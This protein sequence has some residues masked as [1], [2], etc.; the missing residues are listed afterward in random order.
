MLF[1]DIRERRRYRRYRLQ[2]RG[3]VMVTPHLVFSYAVEDISRGGLA[4][5]YS[6]WC[7]WRCDQDLPRLIFVDQAC[8]LDKI[9]MRVVCDR[10]F[11]ELLDPD[12]PSLRRCSVEFVRLSAGQRRSLDLYLQKWEAVGG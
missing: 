1:A 10:P 12:V 7:D 5:L 4:F 2:G 11:D 8:F 3:M 6:G 9:P